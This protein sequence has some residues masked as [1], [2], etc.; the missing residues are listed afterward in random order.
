MLLLTC[1]VKSFKIKS[2][3]LLNLLVGNFGPST[4]G[5][6]FKGLGSKIVASSLFCSFIALC[7]K[8]PIC[9]F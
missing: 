2:K 6:S 8:F 9:V 5:L 4:I 1:L 7:K 3:K